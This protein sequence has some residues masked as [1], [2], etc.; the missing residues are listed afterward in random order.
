[1]NKLLRFPAVCEAIGAC[2]TSLY[3]R[4]RSGTFPRPV[5]LSTRSVA[6]PSEEIEELNAAVIA[7]A[8]SN[9]LRAL[10]AQLHARRRNT[11]SQMVTD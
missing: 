9:D 8:G 10:V 3:Q 2:K 4:I 1:M 7:G 5:R 6:W 11:K